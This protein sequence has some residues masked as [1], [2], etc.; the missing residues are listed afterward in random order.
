MYQTRPATLDDLKANIRQKIQRV[1]QDMLHVFQDIPK[2]LQECITEDGGQLLHTI[3]KGK[4]ISKISF[5]LQY[6]CKIL[7]EANKVVIDKRK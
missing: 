4:L 7:T 1:S 6:D 2:H 5:L 3:F